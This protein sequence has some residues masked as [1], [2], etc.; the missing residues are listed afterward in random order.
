MRTFALLTLFAS[1][2][3]SAAF[4]APSATTPR[5]PAFFRLDMAAASEPSPELQAAIDDVRSCA[6]A[7]SEETAHFAN[8]W[9]DKM[10]EGTQDGMAAGLLDECVLGDGDEAEEKCAKYEAALKKLDGLLGVGAGEQY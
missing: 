4:V 9:I 6:A 7:F 1:S 3:S 2:S 8:V 5:P 10:L